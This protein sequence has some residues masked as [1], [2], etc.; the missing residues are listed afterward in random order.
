LKQLDLWCGPGPTQ[1]LQNLKEGWNLRNLTFISGVSVPATRISRRV[2]TW[3]WR[4]ICLL[5]TAPFQ[6][7]KEDD[8]QTSQRPEVKEWS[9]VASWCVALFK[10]AVAS[11]LALGLQPILAL[12]RHPEDVL[13]QQAGRRVVV[14]IRN[15]ERIPHASVLHLIAWAPIEI[16]HIAYVL[17]DAPSVIILPRITASRACGPT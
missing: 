9:D 6:N 12:A 15:V 16:P 14:E 11:A 8:N 5:S 2:E 1:L 13:K 4:T 17:R 3:L 10:M 7:L